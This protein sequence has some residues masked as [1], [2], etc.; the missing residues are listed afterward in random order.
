MAAL[1]PGFG[2]LETAPLAA[3]SCPLIA[4]GGGCHTY[5]LGDDV[6]PLP[7]LKVGSCAERHS[8][9]VL[10]LFNCRGLQPQLSAF[11]SFLTCSAL[12]AASMARSQ[13]E[14]WGEPRE[15]TLALFC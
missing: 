9:G 1:L 6:D 7:L 3:Q 11:H 5:V 15:E 14:V 2:A 12:A 4:V 13:E 8:S 10:Q